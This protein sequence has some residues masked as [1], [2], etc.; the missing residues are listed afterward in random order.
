MSTFEEYLKLFGNAFLDVFMKKA[1]ISEC[2]TEIE[3][4]SY[5]REIVEKFFQHMLTVL[6]KKLTKQELNEC[7]DIARE[8]IDRKT[9]RNEKSEPSGFWFT[10]SDELPTLTYLRE[11]M[12]ED[13]PISEGE[14]TP[15]PLLNDYL[16]KV[17]KT[18]GYFSMEQVK[19]SSLEFASII[20]WIFEVSKKKKNLKALLLGN[21]QIG[22][23]TRMNALIQLTPYL[24]V[25]LVII[26][27]GTSKRTRK[28][29]QR[30]TEEDVIGFN[31]LRKVEKHDIFT[32]TQKRMGKT[33][34]QDEN[35]NRDVFDMVT[36][37]DQ[38]KQSGD[39]LTMYGINRQLGQKRVHILVVKKEKTVLK[40]LH[41]WLF[42]QGFT[43]VSRIIVLDDESDVASNDRPNKNA[44]NRKIASSIK[45]L[46]NDFP[47]HIYLGITATAAAVFFGN[48]IEDCV[49][50]YPEYVQ[51]INEPPGYI[52]PFKI[53]E[54][55]EPEPE[56]RAIAEGYE[57]YDFIVKSDDIDIKNRANVSNK[58]RYHG[59]RF[60][61]KHPLFL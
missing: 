1:S 61:A 42:N 36:K 37:Q 44:K 16:E 60:S 10:E 45:K 23:T 57:K 2:L 11:K 18:Q 41:D 17:R 53:F 22:K 20:H 56:Y 58:Q 31:P 50:L 55:D 43:D 8:F 48:S 27:A 28:Q 54:I 35:S 32:I 6:G 30:R 49:S 40:K 47:N 3:Q 59:A 33:S 52:S 39:A 15:F 14:E 38:G 34:P 26:F 7:L 46:L 13:Y 5:C 9:L 19:R 29:N 25:E 4:E 51:I 24:D 12:E 21:T